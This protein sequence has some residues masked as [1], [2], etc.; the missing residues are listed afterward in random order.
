MSQCWSV[1]S[2]SCLEL[3][4]WICS[5]MCCIKF[6]KF[7]DM[8]SSNHLPF[9]L[10]L[11]LLGYICWFIWWYSIDHLISINSIDHL[12]S[13]NFSFLSTPSLDNWNCFIFEFPGLFFCPNLPLNSYSKIFISFIVFFSLRI[14]FGS[15]L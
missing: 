10:F 11:V 7:L 15:F 8:I 14:L 6:G 9:S 4:S 2:L 3:V 1:L 5:F 12:I 13:I